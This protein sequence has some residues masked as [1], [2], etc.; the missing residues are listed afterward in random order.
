VPFISI[1]QQMAVYLG[2]A[3]DALIFP[4]SMLGLRSCTVCAN[5][6]W[7]DVYFNPVD[8]MVLEYLPAE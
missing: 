7:F 4:E 2:A 3:E 8:S 1:A 5:G 6:Q